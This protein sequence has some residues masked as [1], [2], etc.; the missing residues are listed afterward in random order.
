MVAVTFFLKGDDI[1]KKFYQVEQIV[2][3]C[4]KD[5]NNTKKKQQKKTEP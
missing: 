2:V 3:G 4:M 1:T 5:G